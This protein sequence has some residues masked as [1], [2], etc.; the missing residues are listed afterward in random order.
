ERMTRFWITLD[1]GVQF[2]VNSLE[3]M[4]GGEIFI[5]KIPSMC[6]M[7]LAK[8]IG[9]DCEID[10]IGIRPGEK[11]HELMITEDDARHTVEFDDYYTIIPEFAGWGSKFE[12][13]K[14]APD[15]FVYSSETNEDWLT[16]EELKRMI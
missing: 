2:V 9:P 3:R 10:I 15:G 6:I 12:K 14:P 1:Q 11:L 5:P 16:V 7:D 4:R 8:A 13:G